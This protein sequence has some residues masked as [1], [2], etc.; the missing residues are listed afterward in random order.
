MPL[1]LPTTMTYKD[2]DEKTSSSH[3]LKH[4]R[5]PRKLYTTLYPLTC[6]LPFKSRPPLLYQPLSSTNSIH[7]LRIHPGKPGTKIKCS[8][9]SV[10]LDE[11]LPSYAA[12]SY[13]WGSTEGQQ[14]I[15]LNGFKKKVNANLYEALKRLRK[16]T[17][18]RTVWIDAL[19]INQD[20]IH[21]KGNQ[22]GLMSDIYSRAMEVLVWLGTDDYE[23]AE[24]AFE[25]LR[26]VVNTDNKSKGKKTDWDLA[27]PK[28]SSKIKRGRSNAAPPVGS[29]VWIPVMALFTNTWFQ[30]MWVLQ[31]IALAQ[32][33]IF[34][35]GA[36]QLDW[37]II[38]SALSVITSNSKLHAMLESRELQNAVFMSHLRMMRLSEMKPTLSFLHLLDRARSF[39]VTDAK[40]KVYGALGIVTS[41]SPDSSSGIFVKPDYSLSVATI[42]TSVALTLISESGNLDVLSFAVHTADEWGKDEKGDGNT[43]DEHEKIPSWVPD[44][45]SK[46]IIYPLLGLGPKNRH[47]TGT[48]RPL[49]LLPTSYPGKLSVKGLILDRV[50]DVCAPVLKKNITES[51]GEVKRLVKWCSERQTNYTQPNTCPPTPLLF[52]EASLA[53]VLAAGR[54][55]DGTLVTDPVQHKLDFIVY[56]SK[57]LLDLE[58]EKCV[59]RT[60]LRGEVEGQI[61]LE[62]AL[63][64]NTELHSRRSL[65]SKPKCEPKPNIP[66]PNT[67]NLIARSPIQPVLTAEERTCSPDAAREAI[68]RAT[69][70]RSLFTTSSGKLGLGPSA[71]KE[72]DVVVALWGA[73]VPF[74]LRKV[75]G[76]SWYR[77]VGECYV[78]EYM[79][80]RG[81]EKLLGG[82][83]VEEEVFELR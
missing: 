34:I 54:N 61:K 7:L 49:H 24:R 12:L 57:I 18:K 55:P 10:L 4:S 47:T 8:L 59:R 29:R 30:R 35:W 69:C 1:C 19:C 2:L 81:V 53:S 75:E 70:Y 60:K 36:T 51:G 67:T 23:E 32:S 63:E 50:S 16:T 38:E 27:K 42:Y 83:E 76:G 58:Q 68:F 5:V 39:N 79:D 43:T 33:A 14:E 25:I 22:I 28:V 20:D 37:K 77:F 82:G 72:G 66:T 11:T 52:T 64:S 78:E 71:M 41:S 73:Q 74:V 48:S 21:E 15:W 45:N 44:W 46:T 9:R 3:Y 80:G 65:E 13:V 62:N 6:C 31:E 26:V 56:Y 17:R 40:D